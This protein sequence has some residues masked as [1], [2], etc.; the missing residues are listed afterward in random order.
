MATKKYSH[1]YRWL[2]RLVGLWFASALFIASITPSWALAQS[3]DDSWTEPLNLSHSG[4]ATNPAIVMDSAGVGHVVW[5]DDLGNYVYTRLDGEQ[6]SAPETTDLNRLFRMPIPGEPT[7]QTQLSMYTGPNP[8]FIAG[9]D[10]NVFAFWISPEGKV[11]TSRVKNLSFEQYAAWDSGRLIASEAG[12]FAVAIDALG[13]LHLAY[14]RTIDNPEN[15][16][17]IYYTRSRNSGSSWAVPVLLYE[18]PY[19]QTLSEGEANISVATAGTEDALRVFIAWDNRPRKQVLLAQSAD[20]G[21]SWEPPALVAGPAAPGSKSADPFNIH[22]G[23]TQDSLVLVWQSG[24]ATNGLLPACSQIYQS[25]EDA[26]ASWSDPQP[27]SEDLL[28]CAQSNQFV[29]SLANS[30]EGPLYFLSETKG[31]VT[32]YAWNGLQWSQPQE[33]PILSGFEEPEIYTEVIYGCHHASLSGERL[34][35]VGCDQ[36]EGG[37]VWVTS[38][39]LGSTTSWFKPLVWSQLSPVTSDNL[40]MEAVELVATDDGL[41]HAFFSQHKDPA[42]YYTYWNDELWSGITSVLKLPEGEAGLPAIAAGPENELFLFVPNNTGTLYFSRATSGNAATAS[43]WSTPTRLGT[44]HDGGIGSVDVARNAAG[45]LYVAYSVPVNEKRGIYL[46]QSKDQG[47]TWSEPLQVFN[48][49]AAGFDLVGAPSLLTSENGFLHITWKQQSIQGDGVS[50]PLSLYYTRSEDGGTTFNDA[51][52][53]V[54]EPVAW[55]EIVTDGKGNLHLLW[56]PQ[57]TVTTVWDQVS[58]DGGRSWQ[59]PQGLPDEGMTAAAVAGDSA[60]GLHVVNAGPGSLG[61]WL[62]EGSRW[63]PEAPPQWSLASQEEGRVD[64]LASAVN[65]QGKMVVVLA[66]TTGTG[67]AAERILLYST[68]TLEQPPRQIAITEVPTRT[69]LPPTLT[70]AT[71]TPEGSKTPASMVDGEPTNSQGQTDRN[72]TNDRISPLTIAL[73]P[74]A[75]LL[76]GVLGYMIRRAVQ[77]KDQ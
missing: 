42:I 36:G 30:P 8:L 69:L 38:R 73:L 37:D 23:A 77:A 11:F 70:P 1:Q 33:Q 18:S 20:G 74:V 39:D 48:G 34:Y 4:I 28:G 27:M 56:Q 41:I 63:Q 50:Q 25:S 6:W 17:G 68:R 29:S 43:S 47:T 46:V 40:E 14:F 55:R 59:F 49:A 57:D 45:T 76:L 75:L 53:V 62:W 35:V 61:H 58:L 24:R 52:Q 72:K 19:F 32:L 13:E 65:K 26:G 71:P 21:E 60:G 44:G 66:V 54:E 22:V 31:Q 67:D 3:G 7:S 16:A 10:E 5:Q 15:P 2:F 9:P 64:L 51:Q 12:S